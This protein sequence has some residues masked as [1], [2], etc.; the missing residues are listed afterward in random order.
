MSQSDQP[1]KPWGGRFA[2]PTD[3][4][5]ERF[6]ASVG[7]DRRLYHH[8]INGSLAHAQMLA[9]VGVL[10]DQEFQ[11][12]RRGLEEI[13]AAIETG[14]FDWSVALEDVHM[15]IEARLTE[16]IGITGK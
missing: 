6:T 3:A 7:F 12:I 10:S 2:E 8:D 5:V 15:N 14:Q 1:I 11:D 4:F 9:K 16:K 13:R